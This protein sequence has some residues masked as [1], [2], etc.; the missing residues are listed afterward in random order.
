MKRI[1]TGTKPRRM[2]A[3][4]R[5]RDLSALLDKGAFREVR[6]EL[7]PKN[8]TV[9]IRMSEALLLAVKGKAKEYDFDYQ[10]FIRLA[11]ERLVEKR[12]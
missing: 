11:L 5:S 8:K 1:K 2:N 7:R 10:K 4:P 12:S 9:T 6:F 3:D